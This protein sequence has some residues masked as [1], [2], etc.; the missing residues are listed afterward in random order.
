MEGWCL[1]VQS[2]KPE[3]IIIQS[4]TAT[5]TNAKLKQ[6]FVENGLPKQFMLNNSPQFCME[7]LAVF[8]LQM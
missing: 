4:M 1:E 2:K 8:T 7:I 5:D 3:A 6:M